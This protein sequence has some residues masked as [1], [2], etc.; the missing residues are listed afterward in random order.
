[1]TGQAS[2]VTCKIDIR[3]PWSHSII[4]DKEKMA[5]TKQINTFFKNFHQ[6]SHY[7]KLKWKN[8]VLLSSLRKKVRL[9]PRVYT[10]YSNV[11]LQKYDNKELNGRPMDQLQ[12]AC[13]WHLA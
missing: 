9:K 13:I 7:S 1:M 10:S 12:R 8:L 11:P 3:G 6:A 2:L 5:R 4:L